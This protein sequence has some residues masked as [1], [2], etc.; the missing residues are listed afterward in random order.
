MEESA[1]LVIALG[2]YIFTIF[3]LGS[4]I[5]TLRK[6]LVQKETGIKQIEAKLEVLEKM[7]KAKSDDNH[8]D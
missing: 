1:K 2:L 7:V 4:K 8:N 3:A 6:R 5:K